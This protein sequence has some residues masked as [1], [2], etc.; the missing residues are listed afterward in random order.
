MLVFLTLVACEPEPAVLENVTVEE[1]GSFTTSAEGVVDVPWTAPD[2][3]VSTQVFCGPYGYDVLATADRIGAPSG[4]IYNNVSGEDGYATAMRVGTA[5]D[6]L[7]VLVPV[8]PKIP[9]EPGEYTLGMY[10]AAEQPVSV[11]CSAI[12]RTGQVA[13]ANTINIDI[14]FVGVDGISPGFNATSGEGDD[15]VQGILADLGDLWGDLGYSVGTVRYSDFDGDVD[16]YTTIEGEKEF[17]DLLRN[18]ENGGQIT[19]FFVQDIAMDDGAS[20]LGLAGGPPGVASV[21][22]TSKSGVVVSVANAAAAPEQVSLIMAHEGGH[23]VGLFHPT[24][25]DGARFDPLDDTPECATNGVDAA[26]ADCGGKGTDNVMWWAAK[27]GTST[28]FS[29]DQAWVAARNPLAIP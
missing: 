26:T 25:K 6:L 4:E 27:T 13:D 16:T 29:D 11:K 14:V 18:A 1:L 21:G 2:D 19:F 23:F 28:A 24:E 3:V 9:A 5:D 8:S 22:G 17:G 10:V 7:P 20:I 15:I 12:N